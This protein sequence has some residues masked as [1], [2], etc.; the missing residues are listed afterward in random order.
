MID[1]EEL[2]N[3]Q[4]IKD[5]FETLPDFKRDNMFYKRAVAAI[6]T[7][8]DPMPQPELKLDEDS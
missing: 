4:I 2:K 7:G 5:Y 8:E 3:W 1:K 6:E